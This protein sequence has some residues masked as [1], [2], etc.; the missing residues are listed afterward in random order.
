MIY[1]K[2]RSKN[3]YDTDLN[4]ILILQFY[5]LWFANKKNKKF[6]IKF[7]NYKHIVNKDINLINSLKKITTN[8]F[9]LKFSKNL[10]STNKKFR[11][12][13]FRKNLI[14]NFKKNNPEVN[15]NLIGL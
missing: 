15:F 8:K 10:S 13:K 6:N 2:D 3:Y 4:I 1:S 14:F 7:I 5:K 12:L 11:I 9:N